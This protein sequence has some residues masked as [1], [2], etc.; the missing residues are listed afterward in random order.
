MAKLTT[1]FQQ[2][3][4][5]IVFGGTYAAINV[6]LLTVIPEGPTRNTLLIIWSSVVTPL[7]IFFGIVS[8]GTSALPSNTTVDVR[9]ALA[10][11]K[12]IPATTPGVSLK[13]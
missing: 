12:V 8:G 2:D 10:Q 13:A 7:A 9:T 1:F 6:I 11:T 3:W 5:K 4:V